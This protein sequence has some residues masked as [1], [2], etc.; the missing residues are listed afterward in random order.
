MKVITAPDQSMGL[1]RYDVRCF[2]AGGITGCW[3]WQ[4]AVINELSRYPADDLVIL[5]PRRKNFPIGDP[6]AAYEQISWEFSWL[7]CCDI[8]SMYFVASSS[9]QPICMYELGRNILNMQTTFTSSYLDRIV[10][11]C[12]TGYRRQQ[13]VE[14][15]SRLA[16]NEDILTN[17]CNVEG[18][19][20]RIIECYNRIQTLWR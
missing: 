14:I 8:F 6:N 20:A 13:D 7:E 16:L 15:Q 10:I 19:A 1:T 4:E 11:T 9:D 18:H 2:L 12:E 5:N 17:P 3:D